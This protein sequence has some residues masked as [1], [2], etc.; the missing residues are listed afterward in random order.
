MKRPLLAIFIILILL[1][2]AGVFFVFQKKQTNPIPKASPL[3]INSLLP[4]A[5][6]KSGE[7][8]TT[9]GTAARL[10]V[11]G[12]EI[13]DAQGNPI[14]LRGFSWGR[15]GTA[16][17]GDGKENAAEGANMVRIPLRWWGIYG[18]ESIDSRDDA[19]PGHID[20][21]HLKELDRM[22][23]DA[24]SAHLWIDLFVDSDCGQ[25]GTQEDKG[26]AKYC[27]PEGKYGSKGRNFWSDRESRARFIEVWKFV[28]NRYKDTPYIG[29]YELLP[30]PNPAGYS[31]QDVSQFYQELI[32]A[33][34]PIDSRT[35]FLIG[36]YK[37]YN[38]K[39]VESA[40]IKTSVPIIYTGNLFVYTDR[41]SLASVT[42]NLEERLKALT[43]FRDKYNV[44]VFV[45]Q[46]GAR[47]GED[48]GGAYAD[49]VLS[50]L[51]KNNVGWAW[52][53]YRQENFGDG[54]SIEYQKKDG[55][56]VRKD[57]LLAIISK[58]FKS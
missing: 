22:I 51:N 7:D 58:Y 39:S 47:S 23:Q 4:Q 53:T 14:V 20:P 6:D 40:Y 32:A 10:T 35:P 52:W 17:P 48:P 27:D 12:S 1:L 19:A 41:G 26:T 16:Q 28:A 56:W 29:M 2:T 15:W 33:I 24:S 44:P 13:L 18:E 50:L 9:P 57:D 36:A 30:E 55:S 46:T 49:A 38:I 8:T 43:D 42:S 11:R 37:G 25:N 45:Q 21:D 31:A 34:R 5:G 3:P 54:F